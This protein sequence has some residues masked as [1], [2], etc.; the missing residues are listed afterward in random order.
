VKAEWDYTSEYSFAARLLRLFV[1][2][3]ALPRL[4]ELA[5]S[6]A[7]LEDPEDRTRAAELYRR[8]LLQ[9]HHPDWEQYRQ[10]WPVV[11]QNP[12]RQAGG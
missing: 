10:Q 6:D 12:Y 2:S 4:Q 3:K 11:E 8:W 7:G 5:A 1:P 9:N